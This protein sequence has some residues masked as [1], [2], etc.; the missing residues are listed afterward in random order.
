MDSRKAIYFLHA[1]LFILVINIVFFYSNDSYN[2][3]ITS[4]KH[5][6]TEDDI[7]IVINDDYGYYS[8]GPEDVTYVLWDENPNLQ[9][10]ALDLLWDEIA[11]WEV[12]EE[13][14]KTIY[15]QD[16]DRIVLNAFS[17][18]NMKRLFEHWSLFDLTSEYPDDYFEYIWGE[19]SLYFFV[20]K[21]YDEVKQIFDAISYTLPFSIKEV[22]LFERRA[23][24]LNLEDSFTDDYVRLV[25]EYKNRVFWLKIKKTMY[26]EIKSVVKTIK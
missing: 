21:T 8:P 25:I 12:K 4:L 22:T 18:Y 17:S 16:D 24:F 11:Q 1:L 26:N 7:Q 10:W 20:T 19:I 5:W 15:M 14:E 2:S 13:E 3:F 23:F 6:N 9:T